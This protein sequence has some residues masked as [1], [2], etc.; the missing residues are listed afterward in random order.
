MKTHVLD[1]Q[2]IV[3][4]NYFFHA[5]SSITVVIDSLG[6]APNRSSDNLTVVI[7]QG[8]MLPSVVLISLYFEVTTKF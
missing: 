5:N 4:I 7:S 8:K 6:S 1:N 2:L 3:G